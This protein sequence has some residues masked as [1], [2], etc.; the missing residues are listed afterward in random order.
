MQAFAATFK[1]KVGDVG[2][3]IKPPKG[4]ADSGDLDQDLT[5]ML[6]ILGEAAKDRNASI[7]L[8]IDEIQY[9]KQTEMAALLAGLH[10]VGQLNLPVMLFGAGLPQVVGF[11][12]TA[13]SYAERLFFFE[14]IGALSKKDAR[15]AIVDP[16]EEENASINRN[17]VDEIFKQTLGYPHFLQEWGYHSWDEA[18]TSPITVADVKNATPMALGTLDDGFFRVRFDRLTPA[19]KNYLRAMAELGPGPHRSGDIAAKLARAVE[20]VAPIRA[21]VISKGMAYASSHGHTGFTVPMFD[22]YMKRVMA[23]TGPTKTTK[24]S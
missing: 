22:A 16:I 10:R 13:K 20:Q 1:V 6:V 11:S 2:V 5:D 9:I 23:W 14:E 7:A 21:R 15:R 8:F 17:A 12:G 24:R 4:T 19:E 3:E 18:D